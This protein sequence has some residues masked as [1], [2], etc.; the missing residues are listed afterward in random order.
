MLTTYVRGGVRTLRLP[1]N[2]RDRTNL[3]RDRDTKEVDETDVPVPDDLD[4]INQ[5]EPTEVINC[6]SVV[7]SSNPPRYAFPLALLC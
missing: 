5:A 1:S 7:F 4:L 6:S 2:K 3:R